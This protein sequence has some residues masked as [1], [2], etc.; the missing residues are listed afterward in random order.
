MLTELWLYGCIL[1]VFFRVEHSTV[2]FSLNYDQLWISVTVCVEGNLEEWKQVGGERR[3]AS[4]DGGFFF[5][6]DSEKYLECTGTY[7]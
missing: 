4:W 1:D 7:I 3:Q 6:K 5:S 2:S